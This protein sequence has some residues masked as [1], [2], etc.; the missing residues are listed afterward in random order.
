ML[1]AVALKR[2]NRGSRIGDRGSG[3]EDRKSGIE[4]R[5]SGIGDRGQPIMLMLTLLEPKL[6]YDTAYAYLTGAKNDA[7]RPS[8]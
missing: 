7:I 3:I 1:Q 4:D 6:C 5:G 2:R 8:G